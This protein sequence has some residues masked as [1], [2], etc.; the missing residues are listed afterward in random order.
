MRP[1][2][3]L[4]VVRDH[5]KTDFCQLLVRLLTHSIALA[6]DKASELTALVFYMLGSGI[7]VR[8][9]LF[10][11]FPFIVKFR[12]CLLAFSISCVA[13]ALVAPCRGREREVP[14]VKKKKTTNFH[15]SQEDERKKAKEK[16]KAE[17][18]SRRKR[19]E[20]VVQRRRK[21]G[22]LDAS[23]A[24]S[25]SAIETTLATPVCMQMRPHLSLYRKAA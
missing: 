12:D 6:V 16:W 10:V 23:S 1:F 15:S 5:R 7:F 9:V 4:H 18:K 22:V 11:V 3:S 20:K 24:A 8:Y 19:K 13:F 17:R 2:D 21:L 25:S 14:R